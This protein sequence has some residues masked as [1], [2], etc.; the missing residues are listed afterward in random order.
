VREN[1]RDPG[2]VLDLW[3]PPNASPPSTIPNSSVPKHTAIAHYGRGPPADRRGCDGGRIRAGGKPYLL[4]FAL[5]RDVCGFRTRRVDFGRPSGGVRRI[6]DIARFIVI[7]KTMSRFL[8]DPVS[9]GGAT[10]AVVTATVVVVVASG[11]M[12]RLLDHSEYPD[13][14]RGM[15]WS[16]QTVTTV[17]YGDV[18]PHKMI[19]RLVATVVMFEGIALLAVVTAAVT[20]SFVE[21]AERARYAA[22]QAA[23]R[24]EEARLDARFDDL[25]ARLERV[26]TMLRSLTDR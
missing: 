13:I 19:G 4:A 17:G 14:F 22:E 7:E 1:D 2:D 8:R 21:R 3:R 26:E 10:A 15:W 9:V 11:V 16:L 12:M 18:T 24:Q 6:G 20:S 5:V 25:T 23:E